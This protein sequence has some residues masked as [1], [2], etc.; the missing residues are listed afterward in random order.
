MI[1]QSNEKFSWEPK[2]K[3]LNVINFLDPLSLVS[4]GKLRKLLLD[5]GNKFTHRM[6][7]IFSALFV[8]VLAEILI[9]AVQYFSYDAVE[10]NNLMYNF[11]A[12]TIPFYLL[13]LVVIIGI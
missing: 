7:I 4:Y 11:T 5:F 10:K 9:V 8:L 12:R 6:Q 3:L 1:Y 13:P 2:D